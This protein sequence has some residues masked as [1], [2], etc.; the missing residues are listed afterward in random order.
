MT[1]Q[2]DTDFCATSIEASRTA[3]SERLSLSEESLEDYRKLYV[4]P[5]SF[6]Y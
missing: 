2:L 4:F 3:S 5:P 1:T 6:T